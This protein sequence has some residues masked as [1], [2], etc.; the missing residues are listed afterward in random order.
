MKKISFITIVLA[1]SLIFTACSTTNEA[2]LYNAFLKTQDITSMESEDEINLSLELKDFPE[3][4]QGQLEEVNNLLK[5][6]KFNINTKQT[7]NKEKTKSMVEMITAMDFNGMKMDMNT[8]VDTDF[9]TDEPKMIAVLKMP[10]ILMNEIPSE[11]GDNK[12]YILYDYIKMLNLTQEEIN[13]DELIKSSKDIN[14][15]A[16]EFMKDYHKDFDPGFP[17]ATYKGQRTEDKN[18]LSI[19]EVKLDDKTFKSLIRYIGNDSI[20]NENNIKFFKEYMDLVLNIAKI[21]ET[22]KLETL[23]ELEN[24]KENLPELKNEFNKFMDTL[25][26][27]KILG[28]EGILIEYAVNKDGYIVEEKGQMTIDLDLKALGKVF[29]EELLVENAGK[30]KLNI[31]FNTKISNINEKVEINIP[32]VNKEN[33]IDFNE[34]LETNIEQIEKTV[35]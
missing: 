15:K 21:P 14:E 31:S 27:V 8:W 16:L 17:I 34:L 2:K 35:E 10:Q 33:A 24:L 28:E 29:E 12:E 20:E 5:N 22:E 26:D 11:D 18:V 32:Q 13:M 6:L 23:S 1:L 4:I 25:E 30:V 19:Y 3:E 7:V 9:S